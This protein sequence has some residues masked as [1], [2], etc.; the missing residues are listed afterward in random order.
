LTNEYSIFNLQ[1]SIFNSPADNQEQLLYNFFFRD[2]PCPSV[3]NILFFYHG[4]FTELHG[5]I[6]PLADPE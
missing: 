1:S 3:V 4:F 5:D 6:K 2:L